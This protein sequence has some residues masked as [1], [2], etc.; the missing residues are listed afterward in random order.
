MCEPE[1]RTKPL[2]TSPITEVYISQLTYGVRFF[3]WFLTERNVPVKAHLDW[4][5][6]RI[7][8][9]TASRQ[10]EQSRV[11][12]WQFLDTLRGSCFQ[13]SVRQLVG[14]EKHCKISARVSLQIP[15]KILLGPKSIAVN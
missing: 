7:Y 11:L 8:K 12:L 13:H 2:F 14:K 4:M 15:A 6:L 5:C 9:Y 10:P 3:D 1:N